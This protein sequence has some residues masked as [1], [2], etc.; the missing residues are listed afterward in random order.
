MENA[1]PTPALFPL[2]ILLAAVTPA[3]AV[4]PADVFTDHMILQRDK[5]VPI[6]GW[7]TPGETVKVSFAG[8]E[9]HVTAGDDGK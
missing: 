4:T 8:Q 2:A 7:A 1:N 3:S 5:P 9:K 6:W